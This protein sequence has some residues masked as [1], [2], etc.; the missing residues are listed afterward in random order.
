MF[1]SWDN[2]SIHLPP[3]MAKQS[4]HASAVVSLRTKWLLSQQTN[5]DPKYLVRRRISRWYL[6][7][8]TDA[9][10]TTSTTVPSLRWAGCF[11]ISIPPDGFV[12]TTLLAMGSLGD[13]IPQKPCPGVLEPN[14]LAFN[15]FA[16]PG[17]FSAW[18]SFVLDPG[19]EPW[20]AQ[21]IGSG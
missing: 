20:A 18:I 21:L 14:H 3:S 4:R 9:C 13:T 16:F 1:L 19:G 10:G 7:G 11:A 6:Q 8:R 12:G 15:C 5:Q 2:D 17:L